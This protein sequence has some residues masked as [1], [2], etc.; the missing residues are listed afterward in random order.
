M[1]SRTRSFFE[2]LDREGLSYEDTIARLRAITI[3]EYGELLLDLPNQNFP[4]LSN[5]LP[6][7]TPEGIQHK[8]TGAWGEHL[9]KQSLSFTNFLSATL[10]DITKKDV[11][12]ADVLDFGCGWGRI[13]HLMTYYTTPGRL[14]GCDAWD[15]SLQFTREANIRADVRKSDT[16]PSELPFGDQ[17]FDLIYAFSI[18][19]HL[20][21]HVAK[22]CLASFRKSINPDGL[23]L[24]TVRPVEYWSEAEAHTG[25]HDAENA[26]RAHNE[27][28]WYFTGDPVDSGPQTY[29]D[30]SISIEY[31]Q[32]NFPGWEV[33]RVGRTLID[34]MQ[35][36]VCLRPVDR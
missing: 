36:F 31:L 35:V 15:N 8:W 33:V 14:Y 7:K 5:I 30:I 27:Q 32:K 34:H 25:K 1:L 17:K 10:Y 26:I 6:S 13:L 22:A 23:V 28:G 11:A 20:N 4:H 21:E 3:D 16:V 12:A 24:I 9:L 2:T 18:F 19:T 29:D